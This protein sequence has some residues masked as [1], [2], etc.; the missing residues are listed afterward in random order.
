MK[1]NY[2]WKKRALS[3]LLAMTMCMGMMPSA[4][5]AEDEPTENSEPTTTESSGPAESGEPSSDGD[6]ETSITIDTDKI[7]SDTESTTI[8]NDDGTTT[9]IDITKDV[10]NEDGTAG[11]K[12][13][14]TSVTKDADGN[15]LEETE[16]VTSAENTTGTETKKDEEGNV[17]EETKKV[18]DAETTTTETKDGEGNVT[19]ETQKT[20]G[21]ENTTTV[22]T[23][24]ETTETVAGDLG[25]DGIEITTK[26]P[27]GDEKETVESVSG[28]KVSDSLKPDTSGE[29]WIENENGSHTKTEETED[30]KT[31][32]TVTM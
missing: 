30:G 23:P 8:E 20:T 4:F 22:T 3:L 7:T 31:V 10:W 2:I 27:T 32:T 25:E 5:A 28:G 12:T 6:G 1:H 29:E 21:S 14:E 15:V 17:I 18:T 26:A 24:T 13:T 11:E 19:E 16:K 9:V